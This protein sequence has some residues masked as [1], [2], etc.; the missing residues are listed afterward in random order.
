MCWPCWD[1]PPTNWPHSC[2]TGKV[3][4]SS[5]TPDGTASTDG[6]STSTGSPS[7]TVS[8]PTS[9]T[10]QSTRRQRQRRG[11]RTGSRP[12]QARSKAPHRADGTMSTAPPAN[13]VLATVRLRHRR[14]SPSLPP[15]RQPSRPSHSVSNPRCWTWLS[16]ISTAMAS[17]SVSEK[18]GRMAE[19]RGRPT[20]HADSPSVPRLTDRPTLAP[21]WNLKEL[22]EKDRD[23]LLDLLARWVGWLVDRY[24]L[25]QVIPT[26]WRNH[27]ALV[28]ELS[29]LRLAW[30]AAYETAEADPGQPL[31][32][33]VGLDLALRRFER[34]WA[35]E[36]C[37]ANQCIIQ[38]RQPC[39]SSGA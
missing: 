6:A 1:H 15:P 26:C 37:R 17:N 21:W 35:V 10:T 30:Q 3:S 39:Q 16:P 19:R 8:G 20:D 9:A 32:W 11:L 2:A 33:H 7:S 36:R 14:G 4:R 13:P 27:G 5:P 18:G 25:S 28:E 22:N 24:D 38:E 31:Q 23:V 12:R 29:A 34:R